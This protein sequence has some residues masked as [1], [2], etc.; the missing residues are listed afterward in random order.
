MDGII[1]GT[2]IEVKIE[3]ILLCLKYGLGINNKAKKK[4]ITVPQDI[5]HILIASAIQAESQ[6]TTAQ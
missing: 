2:I 3:G 4:Y 6:A 5:P 1:E